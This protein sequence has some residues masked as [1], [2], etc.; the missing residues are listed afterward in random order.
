MG[1]KQHP[2]ILQV[3]P[4]GH[5]QELAYSLGPLVQVQEHMMQRVDNPFEVQLEHMEV[6]RKELEVVDMV[7]HKVVLAVV[8][9]VVLA[10]V[11]VVALIH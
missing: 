4:L 7:D 1:H 9:V 5:T 10:V 8:L 6:R 2:Y 11:V 3:V